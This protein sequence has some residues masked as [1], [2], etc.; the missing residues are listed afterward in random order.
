MDLESCDFVTCS[1]NYEKKIEIFCGND[2]A[3]TPDPDQEKC[4]FV[5]CQDPRLLWKHLAWT[6]NDGL[7]QKD[8]T[9]PDLEN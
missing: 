5:S 2:G 1:S 7:N 9:V 4:V 8:Q 3:W 6:C